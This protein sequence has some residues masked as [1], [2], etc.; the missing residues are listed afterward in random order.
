M[1]VLTSCI[2]HEGI[3][4]KLGKRLYL[5][6]KEAALQGMHQAIFMYFPSAIADRGY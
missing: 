6:N 5:E 3:A 2:I 4:R 1:E